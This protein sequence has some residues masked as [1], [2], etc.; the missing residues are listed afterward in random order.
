M[1]VKSPCIGTCVLDP[2]AGHC[3]GCYRTGDEI[4][5]WMGMSDGAKKRVIANAQKRKSQAPAK[6]S[7]D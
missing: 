6:H 5:A 1:P 7:V 2:K 3:V 4:G